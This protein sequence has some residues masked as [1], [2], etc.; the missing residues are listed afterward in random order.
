[1]TIR[2]SERKDLDMKADDLI[3]IILTGVLAT[4]LTDGWTLTRRRLFSVPQPN[5]A[6]VG[7]WVSHAARGRVLHESIAAT[8]AVHTEVLIGWTAHYLIGVAFV[9]LHAILWGTEWFRHPTPAPAFITGI[10][11]V[12][13]PFFIM[14]PA[15]GAG[16]AASRTPRPSAA[17]FHSLVMHAVFGLGLFAA[18]RFISVFSTGE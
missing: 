11:S 1:V 15:M 18:A 17:R 10:A 14:Q 9:C 7:R 2:R 12:V 16:I 5:F 3:S 8:P 6:L 13:A 4:A